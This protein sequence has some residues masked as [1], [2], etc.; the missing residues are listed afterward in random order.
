[1]SEPKVSAPAAF[2][3]KSRILTLPELGADGSELV[4]EVQAIHAAELLVALK[5]IPGLETGDK[6][7]GMADI[8]RRLEATREPYRAIASRGLVAPAFSFGDAREDG[9]AWW[10]DLTFGNQQ[11]IVDAV[12]ELSGLASGGGPAVEAATFRGE[13]RGGGG[14]RRAMGAGNGADPAPPTART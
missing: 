6:P 5:G 12:S 4:V 2:R 3:R 14:R 10:D 8:A 9:K 1:M 11:A 7:V 13:R